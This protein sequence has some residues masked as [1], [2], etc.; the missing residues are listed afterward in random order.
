MEALVNIPKTAS[1]NES[2][3]YEVTDKAELLKIDNRRNKVIRVT[4]FS[5]KEE[6]PASSQQQ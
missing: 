6:T 3:F 5:T 2:Q 1:D 4:R